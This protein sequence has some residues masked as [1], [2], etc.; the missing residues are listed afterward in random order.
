M[1]ERGHDEQVAAGV[2]DVAELLRGVDDGGAAVAQDARLLHTKV[3]VP[4]RG[5]YVRQARYSLDVR[6]LVKN[7][8]K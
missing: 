4:W 2:E 3:L 6:C 8:F 5:K 7:P 1:Y